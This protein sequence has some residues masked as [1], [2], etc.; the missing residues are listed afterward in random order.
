MVSRDCRNQCVCSHQIHCYSISSSFVIALNAYSQ[1]MLT[2]Y[3]NAKRERK[4]PISIY[5]QIQFA[6]IYST[7]QRF[8]R[9]NLGDQ[10]RRGR[11]WRAMSYYSA[12]ANEIFANVN[13]RR[14]PLKRNFS[15]RVSSATR[16]TITCSIWFNFMKF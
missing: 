5:L 13:E 14:R 6:S 9:R 10:F 11:Q 4:P 3:A 15:L 2:K 8:D 16:V 1:F 12:Q 7:I